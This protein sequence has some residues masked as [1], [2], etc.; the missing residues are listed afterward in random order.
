MLLA[1]TLIVILAGLGVWGWHELYGRWSESTDDAYVNG[2]VVEITPQVTGTVVSIGADDGDLVRE[3]QV[4][5][6]FDPND[7]EVG[8]QSAQANLAGPCARSVACTATSTACGR[9]SMPKRPKCRR[10]RKR[11]PTQE[12]GGRRGDF[13]GRTVPRPG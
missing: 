8:L 7:A 9:R 6:Q 3:G 10:P 12:P 5:V 2:N 4:L 13:P 11:Q 1:L